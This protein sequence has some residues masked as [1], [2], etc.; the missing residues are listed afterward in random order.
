MKKIEILLITIAIFFAFTS[1]EKED[2]RYQG[3]LFVEFAPDQYGQ[4][5]TPA[6]ISKEAS[7]IGLDQI[8]LQLIGLAV[9]QEITVNFRLAD[10]IFYIIS[11]D[12]Y[13]A[14][15]PAGLLPSEYNIVK[16][17]GVYGVD[18]SF[19]GASGVTFDSDYGRGSITIPANSQFGTIQ[20]QILRK[21]G[22]KLFFVL[23]DS[24]DI[25]ANKPTS[26]LNYDTPVDRVILLDEDF[27]TDPFGRGWSEIDKDGD[28]YTWVF[29]SSTPSITSDSYDGVPLLPENYLIS[30]LVSIPALAQNVALTFEVAAGGN[31][32]FADQYRIVVSENPITFANCRDATII[33]DYVALTSANS[34]RKFTTATIDFGDYIGKSIYF[35]IVHGN[36]TDQ[37]FILIKD[38]K[39]YTY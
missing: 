16:A 38:L 20:V 29:Y 2:R 22:A 3:P 4:K 37:F 25:R 6:Y 31:S 34:G 17:T 23:E 11:S 15:L 14:D 33:Q 26:L 32:D 21:G 9:P 35:A 27:A 7:D 36:C 1:C 8:G 24:K 19:T 12:R 39:F 28:G 5:A 30:P 10:Q 13:V 18:Y